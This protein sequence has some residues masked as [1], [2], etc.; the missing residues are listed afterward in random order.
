MAAHRLC[1]VALVSCFALSAA[2]DSWRDAYREGSRQ[3][4]V[5]DY[6]AALASFQRAYLVHDEAGILFD[7]G[8][9][10]RLLGENTEAA[11]SYRSYLR[12]KPDAA[13]RAAVEALI[14][15]L[16]DGTAAPPQRPQPSASVPPQPAAAP[17]PSSAP[18]APLLPPPAAAPDLTT[19]TSTGDPGWSQSAAAVGFVNAAAVLILGLASELT[20]PNLV[21]AL[22]IGTTALVFHIVSVPIIDA[23]D[24]A[25]RARTSVRG[26][27]GLRIAAW[28]FYG[29][30]IAVYSI[31]GV[32][33]GSRNEAPATGL[34]TGGMTLPAVLSNVLFAVDATIVHAQARQRR[35]AIRPTLTGVV[36]T[37]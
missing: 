16:E 25:T 36:G 4:D 8:E 19:A 22:P 5:G 27:P 15:K 11:H 31:A 6:R 24:R 33:Y 26:V 28:V 17:V 32:Y 14:A 3:F 13:N 1:L 29:T 10:H 30:A 18:S 12:K 7:I 21:P 35:F 20:L 2:A 23:G 37:F 34:I 9:C